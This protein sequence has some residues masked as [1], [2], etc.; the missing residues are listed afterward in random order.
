M[1][2]G[3]SRSASG[4]ASR[5]RR[6]TRSTTA[7]R[8]TLADA[9]DVLRERVPPT[10][11]TPGPRLPRGPRQGRPALSA[12]RDADHRGPR[13]R[14]HHVVLPGLPA[15]TRSARRPPRPTAS[16][17]PD[18]RTWPIFRTATGSAD[19]VEL[20]DRLGRRPEPGGDPD[21]RV[22]GL[23]RVRARREPPSSHPGRSA[24]DAPAAR[25]GAVRRL[26][27]GRGGRPRVGAQRVVDGRD[28]SADDAGS[29]DP[30]PQRGAAAGELARTIAANARAIR[31]ISTAWPSIGRS[32]APGR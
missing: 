23:D 17:G 15:L 32:E 18:R 19:A 5:P 2:P 21:Q 31:A 20:G 9:I 28:R 11:E 13:R 8:T 30:R 14:F 4:P 1:P 7:T 26:G 29:G 12:L 25:A 24:P 16:R 10:F 27:V 3:C 6:S 22:A